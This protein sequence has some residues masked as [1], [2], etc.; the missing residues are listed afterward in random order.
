MT[1]EITIEVFYVFLL[2]H[3]LFLQSK[4]NPAVATCRDYSSDF[5]TNG[6]L[7][8]LGTQFLTEPWQNPAHI[9]AVKVTSSPLKHDSAPLSV[10]VGRDPARGVLES[11][12]GGWFAVDLLSHTLL[13]TAYTIRHY[14]SQSLVRFAVPP[15]SSSCA[16]LSPFLV[17]RGLG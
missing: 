7:Y 5:D 14:D 12:H 1:A 4:I 6:V 9:G 15:V 17:P 13:P 2:F 11:Q 16:A 3:S 10:F 8:F